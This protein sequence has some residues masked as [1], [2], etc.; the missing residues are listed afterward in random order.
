MNPQETFVTRLR[1]QRGP[2]LTHGRDERALGFARR[3]ARGARGFLELRDPRGSCIALRRGRGDADVALEVLDRVGGLALLLVEPGQRPER[4]GVF[5]SQVEHA[6]PALD[7]LFHLA[8]AIRSESRHLRADLRLLDVA[9]GVLELVDD[10][11]ETRAVVDALVERFEGGRDAP[12]RFAMAAPQRDAMLGAIVAF[13]IPIDRFDA[14]LKLS[15]NR[16]RADRT[17][18]IAALRAEAHPGAAETAAWMEAFAN[19]GDE[20]S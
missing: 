18:V 2:W 11:R 10:A 12:W 1:R 15:Q 17:G 13:R 8:Q 20:R 3:R 16:P 9:H 14:K 6:L 5:T 7:G 19:P 4:L